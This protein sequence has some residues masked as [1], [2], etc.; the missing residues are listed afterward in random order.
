MKK[1][2]AIVKYKI[3]ITDNFEF[4]S[5]GTNPSEVKSDLNERLNEDLHSYAG[6]EFFNTDDV[7]VEFEVTD[8]AAN[9]D[10]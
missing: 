9:K 7:S 8:V 3:G 5:N 1:Y 2:K 10:E 4:E 6:S